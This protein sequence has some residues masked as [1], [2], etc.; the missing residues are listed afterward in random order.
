MSGGKSDP[1]CPQ[2]CLRGME[3]DPPSYAEH[4]GCLVPPG[5]A[6]FLPEC[7]FHFIWFDS[8]DPFPVLRPVMGMTGTSLCCPQ[9]V[10]LWSRDRSLVTACFSP[11]NL[12]PTFWP[13]PFGSASF[14]VIDDLGPQEHRAVLQLKLLFS[15]RH[16]Y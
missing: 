14:L 8:T 11:G 12:L 6:F 4:C 16:F 13:R 3:Q 7:N 10:L 1:K 5:K 15:I 2:S 9:G